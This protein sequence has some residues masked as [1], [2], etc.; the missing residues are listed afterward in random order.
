[1]RSRCS[2]G[3]CR[4]RARGVGPGRAGRRTRRG[5]GHGDAGLR[6]VG[7]PA[8]DDRLPARCGV[9]DGRGPRT[10][11]VGARR[12]DGGL[13]ACARAVGP[14]RVTTC[15]PRGGGR[16][17]SG[18]SSDRGPGWHRGS[19]GTAALALPRGARLS[20]GDS[21]RGRGCSDGGAVGGGR[22]RRGVLRRAGPGRDRCGGGERRAG[23]GAGAAAG[24]RLPDRRRVAVAGV[25]SGG[26]LARCGTWRGC[27]PG[28]GV[29]VGAAAW[30][31]GRSAIRSPGA[32]RRFTTY[33]S[34]R[35][36]RWMPGVPRRG[37]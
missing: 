20:A 6:T 34:I 8:G 35:R 10:G 36:M 30:R 19:G 14:G 5:R 1:M 37:T 29:S 26:Y 4:L 25:G 32:E 12:G 21:A 2:A 17:R 3:G 23:S 22:R 11:G 31:C 9:V 18:P 16:E 28:C 27:L 7:S 15:R 24:R 33:G 13:G